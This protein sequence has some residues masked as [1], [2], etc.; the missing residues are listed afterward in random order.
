MYSETRSLSSQEAE[1]KLKSESETE[2]KQTSLSKLEEENQYIQ[3]T[4]VKVL[5]ETS[6]LREMFNAANNELQ[7]LKKPALIVAEVVQV[8]QDKA[9]IRL[10]NA[11]KFFS[12]ISRTVKD[13]RSGDNVLVDQKSLNVVEKVN[14]SSNFD[15][16]RFVIIDKPK[17][18]WEKVGGLPEQIKEIKEVIEL[19]LTKPELFE[20]IGIQP[21]KGVLLHG[22]P[23]TGKTLLAKAVA[24]STNATFIEVV[25][26]ELVQ[27]FIGEGAKLVKEIFDYARNKAPAIVFIDEI[28]ALASVRMENGTS[29]E[30]EVN[31][32][33]MQLLA[34]LDGFDCMD[35]VKIIAAT[36]RPDI[37]DPALLRPGRLDRL[38]EIG[39]PDEKG[40]SEILNVHTQKMNLKKVK[41]DELAEQMENFSGAE[42]KAV[43]TE[44][45]YFAIREGREFVTHQDFFDAVEKVRWVDEDDEGGVIHG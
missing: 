12:H 26:S 44:A 39:L 29:G 25:A 30:R 18:T 20:K 16:E 40:R 9:I 5:E 8:M 33:F 37:I 13:L 36:N 28:D 35:K 19:P 42:I 4:L 22:P 1:P 21:P 23:G 41:L 17:E 38:L 24:Q 43:C 10:P 15:V 31:R 11:N 3:Q 32:T 14:T 27:K 6:A 45:G 2:K 34:E 7:N